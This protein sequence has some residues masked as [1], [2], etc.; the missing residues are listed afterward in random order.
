MA[1]LLG[2]LMIIFVFLWMVKYCTEKQFM[3]LGWGVVVPPNSLVTY[4]FQTLTQHASGAQ[5]RWS[6]KDIFSEFGDLVIYPLSIF[7]SWSLA[8]YSGT[9]NR[10]FVH[11]G[12]NPCAHLHTS[13]RCPLSFLELQTRTQGLYI[14]NDGPDSPETFIKHTLKLSIGHISED[15]YSLIRL[16]L[17]RHCCFFFQE[18]ATEFEVFVQGFDIFWDF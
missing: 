8:W 10:I 5:N 15:R 2:Q 4:T 9:N 7:F 16:W 11:W 14:S 1:F 12:V 3:F 13:V 18:G 17:W 6:S